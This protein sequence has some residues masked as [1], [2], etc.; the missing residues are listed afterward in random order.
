MATRLVSLTLAGFKSIRRLEAFQPGNLTVLIGANG[1]GKSNLISFFRA[2]GHMM[3]APTG[4][5]AHLAQT[6]KAHS[7]LHDGPGVT[8]AIDAALQ[9]ETDK[10]RN[11]YEFGLEYAAGDRLYFNYERFR[12]LPTGTTPDAKVNMG[13][14]HEESKLFERAERGEPTPFA[15]RNMLRRFIIH[16]FHNTSFTSRM[17]QAWDLGEGR[18][19]K[20]DGGNLGVFLYRLKNESPLAPYYARIVET[21]RQSLPFFADFELE[22][23]NGQLTLAWH[24]VNSDQVFAA[25]QASDGMLRFLA[26]VALLL[27]PTENLPELLILDEPELGL[28]PHAIT[29]VAGLVKSA[30]LD[31]QVV[32]ATQSVTFL[33][34]FEPESIVVVERQGRESQFRRLDAKQLDAWLAQYTVGELW[35]KNILGGRP[36]WQ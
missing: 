10:G 34:E 35:E 16:Q 13:A 29:T 36:T 1:A 2:L 20:E 6:G 31:K 25:H 9:I 22:P 14:G 27:Q 18:W 19:L 4:L 11:D 3:S 26:L 21:I 28:H 17:R 12:F 32:L 8:S 5:Q 33:N 24:E 7:W 30:S 23:A 15:I